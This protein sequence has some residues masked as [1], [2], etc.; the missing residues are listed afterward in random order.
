MCVCFFVCVFCV[1][2]VYGEGKPERERVSRINRSNH[3]NPTQQDT[4][5][6]EVDTEVQKV[7]DELTLNI[8]S[9][10]P[11]APTKARVCPCVCI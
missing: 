11:V 5:E 6:E 7:L 9:A 1:G 10:A 8:T 3:T 2:G 4:S